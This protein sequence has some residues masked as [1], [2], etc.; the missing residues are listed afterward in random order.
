MGKKKTSQKSRYSKKK[1]KSRY[2][3]KRVYRKK[4]SKKTNNTRRKRQSRKNINRRKGGSIFRLFGSKTKEAKDE[5]KTG[6]K[7]TAQNTKETVNQIATESGKAVGQAAVTTGK[8]VGQAAVKTGQSLKSTY[9]K[10]KK[11]KKKL[12]FEG[13]RDSFARC[14]DKIKR[15]KPNSEIPSWC[16]N[17]DSPEF[18]IL[19]DEVSDV[20]ITKQQLKDILYQEDN[21]VAVAQPVAQPVTQPVAQPVAQPV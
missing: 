12:E 9:K 20:P 15:R 11:K 10:G 3:K 4:N 17:V 2:S 8:A 19:M 18:K 13:H 16:S 5:I 6:L 7:E 1:Q 21:P 14:C